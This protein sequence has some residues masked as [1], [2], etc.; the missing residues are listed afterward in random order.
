MFGLGIERSS[1]FV[2][3][4]Q[5]RVVAHEAAGQR[6]LLPLAKGDFDP[7]GPRGAELRLQ[8]CYQ[9]GNDVVGAGTPDG[10]HDRRLVVQPRHVADTYRVAGPELETEEVLERAA[11]RTRH[12]S[13]GTRAS[14]TSSTKIRPAFGS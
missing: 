7:L 8:P 6:E 1:G 3:H 13:A 5:Q 4:Q 9:P 14:S 11:S 12:L 10:G 2:E